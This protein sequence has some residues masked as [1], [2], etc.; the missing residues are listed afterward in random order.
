MQF[1]YCIFLFLF[2]KKFKIFEKKIVYTFKKPFN[3]YVTA[4]EWRR[5]PIISY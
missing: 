2:L 3:D 5:E 4:L 1:L